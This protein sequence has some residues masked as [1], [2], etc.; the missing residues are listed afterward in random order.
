MI[1]SNKEKQIFKMMEEIK[2]YQ[3]QISKTEQIAFEQFHV[4]LRVYALSIDEGAISGAQ[5]HHIWPD[6]LS[7][8]S[9]RYLSGKAKLQYCVL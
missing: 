7:G 9:T 8:V 4:P 2:S 5:V 3:A 6:K 1:T